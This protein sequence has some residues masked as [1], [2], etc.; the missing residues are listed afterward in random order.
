MEENRETAIGRD[1]SGGWEIIDAARIAG[2]FA[3]DLGVGD[4]RL[5]NGGVLCGERGS[6]EQE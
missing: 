1:G 5:R 3:E 2:E 6:G 4:L